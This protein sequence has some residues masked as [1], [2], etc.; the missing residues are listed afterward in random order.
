V[1][2]KDTAQ[3]DLTSSWEMVT[4]LGE[5]SL[6]LGVNYPIIILVGGSDLASGCLTRSNCVYTLHNAICLYYNSPTCPEVCCFNLNGMDGA[7]G[8]LTNTTLEDEE[9]NGIDLTLVKTPLW[10]IPSFANALDWNSVVAAV[11]VDPCSNR[12]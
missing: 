11:S 12:K 5:Y 10:F 1:F 8:F 4:G 2:K 7:I 3:L 6:F 9:N